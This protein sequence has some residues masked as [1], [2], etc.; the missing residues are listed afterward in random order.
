MCFH[1]IRFKVN[2]VGVHGTPFYAPKLNFAHF[3]SIF[4]TISWMNKHIHLLWKLVYSYAQRIA[5][6]DKAIRYLAND[7]PFHYERLYV[8][9]YSW[10]CGWYALYLNSVL[11]CAILL[12]SKYTYKQIWLYQLSGNDEHFDEQMINIT[13][14]VFFRVTLARWNWEHLPGYYLAIYMFSLGLVSDC[15]WWCP[16]EWRMWLCGK[17]WEDILFKVFFI[18]IGYFALSADAGKFSFILGR[19]IFAGDLSGCNSVSGL[20]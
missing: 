8:S 5:L 20:A 6:F 1:S 4:C 9:F 11:F 12:L 7:D 19:L 15:R 13:D 18:G 2:K 16:K 10:I 14:A 17:A 3:F